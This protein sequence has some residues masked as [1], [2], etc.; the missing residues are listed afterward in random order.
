MRWRRYA[1]VNL[2]DTWIMYKTGLVKQNH[3]R[4]AVIAKLCAEILM[5]LKYD[6]RRGRRL[7]MPFAV[8]HVLIVSGVMRWRD[9]PIRMYN[10]TSTN[11]PQ[12]HHFSESRNYIV[13]SNLQ[14]VVSVAVWLTLF[15]GKANVRWPNSRRKQNQIRELCILLTRLAE[16]L[17]FFHVFTV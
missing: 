7:E 2:L 6:P 11:W 5:E 13:I 4:Y 15:S 3:Y 1:V 14:L 12:V 17:E 8:E 9:I 16:S 10:D